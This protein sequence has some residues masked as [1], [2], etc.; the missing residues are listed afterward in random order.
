[1]NK[2]IWTFQILLTLAMGLFG[3]QKVIGSIPDL[4]AQGMLWIADFEVWQVRTIGTLEVLGAL[5]L[6]L[7]YAHKKLPRVLVPLASGG[8]ALTMVGAVATHVRRGD[9]ALSI[10]ITSV[11]FVMGLAVAVR[12]WN[13]VKG[14][15]RRVSTATVA[16]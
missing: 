1:M 15:A 6:T 13:E 11:L 16:A 9:P 3:L 12:R 7:P 5:G 4:I 8:L 2:L 10:V 14:N